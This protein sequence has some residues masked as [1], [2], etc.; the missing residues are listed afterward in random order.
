M[1]LGGIITK[2]KDYRKELNEK[3]MKFTKHRSMILMIL[4]NALNPLS[5]EE[6]FLKMKEE[7][8]KVN[9][10]TVYRTME[11]M[12][13]NALVIKTAFMDDNL[14]RYEFN[15]M[16]HKHRL[17]CTGCSRMVSIDCCPVEEYAASLCS[18]ESFELTGHRLEIYG[19]CPECT[20]KQNL[21]KPQKPEKYE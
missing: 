17:V 21:Q 9:L 13:E 14:S 19:I 7:G 18:R 5:A 15:R 1:L 10:S 6:I 16:E 20:G 3:G 2:T 8:S 12:A 4:D 11:I